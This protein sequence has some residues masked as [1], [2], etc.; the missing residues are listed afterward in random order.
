MSLLSGTQRAK[1]STV[2]KIEMA[3]YLAET[4]P[5][6]KFGMQ[7]KQY[8][9]NAY[10]RERKA[11]LEQRIERRTSPEVVARLASIGIN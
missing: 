8:W 7:T 6:V 1:E 2:N 5:S 3:T 11:K 10:M 9:I 4:E